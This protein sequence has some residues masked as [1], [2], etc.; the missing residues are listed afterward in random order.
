MGDQSV[1]LFNEKVQDLGRKTWKSR[2]ERDSITKNSN[3]WRSMPRLG[4][5]QISDKNFYSKVKDPK[6]SQKPTETYGR[7]KPKESSP[8]LL[9]KD[10]DDDGDVKETPRVV[11]ETPRSISFCSAT[12]P[13]IV[14]YVFSI[15][16]SLGYCHLCHTI[17]LFLLHRDCSLKASRS[18]RSSSSKVL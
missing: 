7:R 15:S 6:G 8:Y 14:F 17:Y 13:Y 3:G 4:K 10:D 12:S 5:C 18:L 1:K 16:R 2:I 11:K 9:V